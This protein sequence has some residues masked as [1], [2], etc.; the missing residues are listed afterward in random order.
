M[1]NFLKK[2]KFEYVII[3]SELYKVFL[4]NDHKVVIKEILKL[5]KILI[6]GNKTIIL[7]TFNLNFPKTKKT[8]FADKYIMTGYLN[9]YLIKK[10]KFKRTTKP[11]YNYA[12]L[13]PNSKKLLSLKQKTAWGED[14]IIGF[15]VKNNCLGMGLNIDKT[16]FNWLAIHYCEEKIGVPYRYYKTFSGKNVNLNK[17]VYEKMYVRDLESGF[18]ESGKKL[19]KKLIKNKRLKAK[20]I[21]GLDITYVNLKEY[22]IEAEKFIKK[23]PYSLVTN[24]K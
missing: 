22:S 8:G 9:R 23:D 12:I 7:P 20:K 6:K 10:L 11:M 14:S 24:E 15:L 1:L 19:N 18:V 21:I 3:F 17:N 2:E 4:K 5:I 13:G 16:K